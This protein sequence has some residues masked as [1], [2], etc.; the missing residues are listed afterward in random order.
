MA[1]TRSCLFIHYSVDVCNIYFIC[2]TAEKK[3]VLKGQHTVKIHKI[4]V[5]DSTTIFIHQLN[6][7]I[8]N[9]L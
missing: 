8:F 3:I 6:N 9:S 1:C 5:A 7:I 2:S 4:I